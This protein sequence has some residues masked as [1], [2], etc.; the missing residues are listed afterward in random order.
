MPQTAK[1]RHLLIYVLIAAL[2]APLLLLR[3][4]RAEPE[5]AVEALDDAPVTVGIDDV[6]IAGVSEHAATLTWRTNVL[7]DSQATY[8]KYGAYEVGTPRNATL[9]YGHQVVLTGL[10]SGETYQV[11]LVSASP[12]APICTKDRIEIRTRG[13]AGFREAT[14]TPAL[15]A[16]R[17]LP[18]KAT[19]VA[20]CDYDGDGDLD[21]LVCAEN[22]GG[23]RLFRNHNGALAKVEG[24]A[25][26]VERARASAWADYDGDG[27][28]DLVMSSSWK[29][30]LLENLG[31]PRGTFQ[32]ASP[33]LPRQPRYSAEGIGWL[34]YNADGL[35]DILVANGAY[36]L[37]LYRNTG[38]ANPRFE[39]VSAKAGLGRKGIG[40]G[41]S[42]FPAIADLDGDGFP[43]FLYNLRGRQCLFA[44]N[45]GGAKFEEVKGSGLDFRSRQRI[46]FALGDYDGDGD[47]D[48]FVP[49]STGNKLFRNEGKGTFAD[50]TDAAGQLK[51]SAKGCT[52]AWAD[53]D[54]DGD[55]DLYVGRWYSP[56]MLY[57]NNGDGTFVD[58][59]KTFRLLQEGTAT[60]RGMAFF[61]VEQDGDLDLFVSNYRGANLF[62]LNQT[63]ITGEKHYLR[64][65]LGPGT[66]PLNAK[67]ELR[68]PDGELVGYREVCR[69]EGWGCQIPPVAHF[70]C[71]PGTYRVRILCTG[72]R[73]FER[74]VTTTAD[75]PNVVRIP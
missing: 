17:E 16:L 52:A 33:L 64:V 37:L 38:K 36:G 31:A 11:C 72:K 23:T 66:K 9:A 20:C 63:A 18:S 60:A 49:M 59:S 3:N 21:L 35:P 34:D 74:A 15:S 14:S 71:L 69:T 48:V 32:A 7:A 70:G 22:R 46:A 43:D 44:R 50:V 61:D 55:L 12:D 45:V 73:G 5:S 68:R 24:G 51:G 54:N 75:G 39:D 41:L 57:V 4:Q 28:Q 6:R 58:G 10:E 26:I 65:E 56:D 53:V 40:V 19:S 8:G 25:G 47:L 1:T 42:D 67:V 29:L 62:Y 27:D 30:N 2:I 13:I